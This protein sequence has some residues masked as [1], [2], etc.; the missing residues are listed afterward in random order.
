MRLI[1]GGVE[2]T[3]V[4]KWTALVKWRRVGLGLWLGFGEAVLGD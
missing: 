4:T 2:I 3:R 1:D